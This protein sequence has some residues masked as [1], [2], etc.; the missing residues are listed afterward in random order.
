M[1]AEDFKIDFEN[2]KI[3]YAQ[4]GSVGEYT[5]LEFYSYLQDIFNEAGNM[6][7]DIPIEAESKTKYFL[8]NGWTIDEKVRKHLRGGTLEAIDRPE[9]QRFTVTVVKPDRPRKNPLNAPKLPMIPKG[10]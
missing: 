10:Y 9:S 1:I 2:K 6:K 5:I 4:K 7:Y 8:V 3:N